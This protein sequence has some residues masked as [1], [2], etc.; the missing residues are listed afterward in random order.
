M[1]FCDQCGAP[2][3]SAPRRAEEQQTASA[4]DRKVVTIL[5]A[6]LSGSTQMQERLD[7]EATARVMDRVQRA[8]AEA[9][10][11]NGGRVVK[12]TGDGL[13]AVFGVPTLREDD[14]VRAVRAGI[15]MQAAFAAL[16]LDA[17]ALRVGINTGEVVVS[18]DSDDVVG[19]PVNVAARLEGAAGL[20]EVFVGPETTRLVRD[21]IPLEPVE[22]LQLKGKAEA[23]QASRVIGGVAPVAPTG[24]SF[25][26]RAGDLASLLDAF[27][28]VESAQAAKLVT[29]VGWPGLGKSRLAAEFA[30]QVAD[31]ATVIEA[32]FVQGG[33][34]SFGPIAAVLRSLVER[35]DPGLVL[36]LGDD[37][38]RVTATISALARGGNAGS[39]EQ[40]F[41]AIRRALQ[42]A[43][44][45]KTVV[46]ILDDIHWAEPAMLD[47]VEHLAEWLSGGPVLLLALARPELRD[48][49]PG[50]VEAGG[51]SSNVLV[52]SGLD[53]DA[54]RALA[55]EVLD[56]DAVP[57]EVVHRVLNES[58]G[59]PLFLRELLRLL[60]D[61][62]VLQ[63]SVE[64]ER[65]WVLTLELDAIQLPATIHAALA[66]RIEQLHPDERA[67]LQAASVI[68]RHFERG[69]V[70]LLV[71]P[72]VAAELDRHLTSLHR[73]A[74]VD[75]EGTWWRDEKLFRFHHVLIRDA[76]YRRVLKEMR[77][78]QHV[79]YADWL[80][81]R[82][83]EET[84]EYDEVLAFHLEQALGYRRELGHTPDPELAQR[85]VT[86]LRAAGLRALASDDVANASALL[87]RARQLAPDDP[88][89]LRFWCEAV[90][91]T[92]DVHAA[93]KA[94]AELSSAARDN[95]ERA[96]ADV[97]D[98]QLA[99]QRTPDR[100]REVATRACA[101]AAVLS[102][103]ADDVGVAHAEAVHA[104]ALA[105]LG[106]VG[107]AEA[108]L[109]RSLAAARR[110]GDI[111]RANV[112]L[113]IAPAAALWG[114]SPIARASGRCLDVVRVL[115]I[116]SW[117]PHVEAHALRHQAVLE[118]L[119]ERA[120]AARKMLASA[121]K[122]FTD[123]GHRLGL[124]E[125]AMYAG[126]VELLDG[127]PAAA[128]EPL[129]RARD[130]FE[131]L[132]ARTS[133]ARATA[134]LARTLLDLDRVAEAGELA[135]PLLAGEDLKAK[136]GL[137]GVAAEV[138]ARRG[139]I[140]EAEGL[141]R[142]AVALAEATDALVDHAD[143]RLALAHVL[144]ASGRRNDC[145]VE[146]ARARDLYAAKGATARVAQALG[147]AG[148]AETPEAPKPAVLARRVRPNEVTHVV[149]RWDRAMAAGDRATFQ[150]LHSPFFAYHDHTVHTGEE[151]DFHVRSLTKAFAPN[152]QIR[153]EL[154]AS[155]GE[156]HALWLATAVV[157]DERGEVKR[158]AVRFDVGLT[159][160]NGRFLRVD[161]FGEHALSEALA[162]LVES[163]AEEECEP[164]DRVRAQTMAECFRHAAHA[165]NAGDWDRYGEMYE[166]DCV[167]VDD[168]G[169]HL[170]IRGRAA[171]TALVRSFLEAVDRHEMRL[172][173]VFG[174]TPD[175]SLCR[176]EVSGQRDGGDFVLYNLIVARNGPNGRLDRVEMFGPN[177]IA[178]AWACF[179]RFT[180]A[181]TAARQRR[182]RHN[183]A[184]ENAEA[185]LDAMSSHDHDRARALLSID[186]V[187]V[188]HRLDHQEEHGGMN[189][190]SAAR[191]EAPGVT[192]EQEVLAALG[193]RHAIIRRLWRFPAGET[194]GFVE[195]RNVAVIRVDGSGLATR[196]ET[197]DGNQDLWPA[198]ACA[199]E[200][201]A[202][203]ELSGSEAERA[204]FLARTCMVGRA[205]TA[206]DWES[207]A[208]AYAEDAVL[209][210]HRTGA[211][212][213]VR[214][215]E[216]IIEH[217]RAF[218]ESCDEAELLA[219]DV[220]AFEF[221]TVLL[222]VTIRGRNGGSRFDFPGLGVVHANA[223]GVTDR[224]EMFALEHL[225]DAWACFD[226]LAPASAQTPARRVC[227][228]LATRAYERWSDST[229][230]GDPT[231]RSAFDA[232]GYIRYD[233]ALR[234]E[235]PGRRDDLVAQGY[236]IRH[237]AFEP[238]A[239]L[240][241]RHAL[242]RMRV[243]WVDDAGD[244]VEFR[245][246]AVTR[247]DEQGLVLRDD[248]FEPDQ[249]PEAL[250]C[251]IDR[252]ADDEL[253]GSDQIRARNMARMCLAP[254]LQ[255]AQ[256]W[257]AY[258][259]VYGRDC[260]LIDRRPAGTKVIG[261]PDEVV[262]WLAALVEVTDELH[263]DIVDVVAL[264]PNAYVWRW[265]A[266]GV[267]TGG[268]FE[269]PSLIVG[270]AGPAGWMEKV[271]IFSPDDVVA[272]MARFDEFDTAAPP[273]RRRAVRPNAASR[274]A[275]QWTEAFN[276]RDLDAANAFRSESYERVDHFWH[277]VVDRPTAISL[278]DVTSVD[279]TANIECLATLGE[280]HALHLL[281]FVVGD[282]VTERYFLT[283][284]DTGG[285]RIERDELFGP[286]ALAD[287]LRALVER[288][289]EVELSGGARTRAERMARFWT[290]GDVV[291]ASDWDAYGDLLA[292]DSVL[293]D[294]RSN[295]EFP[296]VEQGT[297][298]I[299]EL[300]ALVSSIRLG[301]A[302][303]L[304]LTPNGALVE[305]V[306]TGEANGGSFDRSSYLV[307]R[308]GEDGRCRRGE[309]FPLERL[310][311]AWASFEQYEASPTGASER[312]SDG[313]PAPTTATRTAQR[314]ARAL[315]DGDPG[316]IL[317]VLAEDVRYDDR[318]SITGGH[319]VGRDAVGEIAMSIAHAPRLQ[320]VTTT[321]IA[322]A[323]DRVALAEVEVRFGTDATVDVGLLA[324][325]VVEDDGLLSTLTVFESNDH[326]AAYDEL[327]S[328]ALEHVAPRLRDCVAASVEVTTAYN[329]GDLDR[330]RRAFVPD[331]RIVDHRPVGWGDLDVENYIT[332]VAALRQR[333]PDARMRVIEWLHVDERCAALRLRVGGTSDG[334]AF[335]SPIL[336]VRW[337]D[338]D[339]VSR[340][341][342]H[343]LAN[344][345]RVLELVRRE[346]MSASTG[347]AA[348]F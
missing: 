52:L 196:L 63:R 67:V 153:N 214:G 112:V 105:G 165:A 287:A 313:G 116:T 173:D 81:E 323:G 278:D 24:T 123:L 170:E 205:Y 302:D 337:C 39:T 299:R 110:A 230:A 178:G 14:A 162:H 197:F 40:V 291:A 60:V 43:A 2:V 56:A 161:A 5:F 303:V 216:D 240:G 131:A 36:D 172:V 18:P 341:E 239:S 103:H 99:G 96:V 328:L 265:R 7:A 308:F 192:V 166:L 199:L 183:K 276:R 191:I 35:D 159:D 144:D 286:E 305:N 114:P 122:T 136:I 233:H 244:E 50:L 260:V 158:E 218:R 83:G 42:A 255:D 236:R 134:L 74:L 283:R 125:T 94:V 65:R 6:D 332:G 175:A 154:L 49:R 195:T 227:P 163:W 220:L 31:R 107:A 69:A 329:S 156:R 3:A 248:L 115:R 344:A 34:S 72:S 88:E 187:H 22:P 169:D 212:G 12:S 85:A 295:E 98:A 176:W 324:V 150:S 322:T 271:E 272:A 330:L 254:R 203:D 148:R 78:E 317:S 224:V 307:V 221:D 319:F 45:R 208:Q 200:R 113:S 152:F 21:V 135:D 279:G 100:L 41:W 66:A 29:V 48:R 101:A 27:N 277:H 180:G 335:E 246:I 339:R 141:A 210:D 90:V 206:A 293:V 151:V 311:D 259:E 157:R 325:F 111:R 343:D 231:A 106:Q 326:D 242:C 13:M 347:R 310:D 345:E 257:N 104:S 320:T 334:S 301:P 211:A 17:V 294:H 333:S 284:A 342:L 1:K 298:W 167:V 282:A 37:R 184:V 280:R 82:V 251:L 261:G 306:V 155:L 28:A 312:P 177:D 54:S 300:A 204:R 274:I 77:A 109:D 92:G 127:N 198:I 318:R 209:I 193:E 75:P 288:W 16:A 119:R 126:L 55:L 51:P 243:L 147:A 270:K 253:R 87:G 91:S 316:P 213:E 149:E 207:V 223:A 89:L 58:E 44:S 70:A 118:A 47:L 234:A 346:E 59:N 235:L 53:A 314:W 296:G 57:E 340:I 95:R 4:G 238:L 139:S 269:L 315:E 137:L 348:P 182:V 160:G 11:A 190:E 124:L 222:E 164:E 79:K 46:V 309:L 290:Y 9:V 188:N 232:P 93:S 25:V 128:E 140:A 142:G 229:A 62:G 8:L 217:F 262:E 252:W 292:E 264:T 179:D 68:G 336:S 268:E 86:H 168:P 263:N 245:R 133:A 215:R 19:D 189:A 237:A 145:E 80:L 267:S 285:T 247:V 258:A 250:S 76:A 38:E 226:R 338:G 84:A 174:L 61:D 241:E 26:G 304:A 266:W 194:Y 121:R 120:D 146:L 219:R 71:S 129:R 32:R 181:T 297:A 30:A 321:P 73:R 117:A 102:E 130:G 256:D 273:K 23:V 225:D 33:G 275:Q 15:D 10:Q 331:A 143:A 249:L 327:E 20:G 138:L 281:R 185:W 186:R 97:Y 228:N 108:A 202:E 132:G 201:W 64:S 289:A 171:I